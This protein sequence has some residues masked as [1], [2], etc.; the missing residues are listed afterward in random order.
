MNKKAILNLLDDH[1]PHVVASV[2]DTSN[3]CVSVLR[4]WTDMDRNFHE[5]WTDLPWDI[6]AVKTYIKGLI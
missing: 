6:D 3:R 2:D 5:E 1:P 4:V